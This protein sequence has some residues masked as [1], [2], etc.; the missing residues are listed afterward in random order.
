MG[1]LFLSLILI[2]NNGHINAVNPLQDIGSA[3]VFGYTVYR[4][5]VYC[6]LNT[7]IRYITFFEFILGFLGYF[8]ECFSY[9]LVYHN[10]PPPPPLAD[11]EDNG[12]QNSTD[13]YIRFIASCTVKEIIIL[14]QARN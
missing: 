1:S 13:F 8:G 2:Y 7:G 4:G 14:F 9:I 10:P 11:P 5:F 12:G 3:R 6:S